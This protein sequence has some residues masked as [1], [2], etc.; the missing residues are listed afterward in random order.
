MNAEQVVNKIIT[1]ANAQADSI[2]AEAQ[3]KASAD[4]AKLDSELADFN[5]K[6]QNL[7]VE[8]GEDK[9]ARMLAAARMENSKA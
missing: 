5:A 4:K 8:A 7:A 6:T 9:K 2:R 1:E 3:E